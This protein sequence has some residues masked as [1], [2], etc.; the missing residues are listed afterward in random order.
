MHTEIIPYEHDG[1]QFEGFIA[2]DE[3]VDGARPGVLV[4]HAWMGQD[5]FARDK[6]VLLAELGYVGF[7]LD[8]YGVGRRASD[9]AG[10]EALMM[11][12]IEDRALLRA[13]LNASLERIK[14]HEVVDATRTACIGFCFGGLC[15]IDLAR[16]GADVTGVVSFHGLLMGADVPNQRITAKI[17]ALH[18][19][20]DPLAPPDQVIAFTKEMTDAGVDWQLHAYG[21]TMHAFT[22]PNA[23]DV[24][25]G[26]VYHEAADRRSWQA[27]RDFFG[28][29]LR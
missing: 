15:A 6:A 7:A 17:L 25:F 16:S 10:A 22:N 2:Y 28:E 13:R 14:A 1:H 4:A 8:V 27:M 18:G 26:T 20:D 19:W 12:L 11:P 21:G 3:T 5:D 9:R 23:N 24:D 29:V